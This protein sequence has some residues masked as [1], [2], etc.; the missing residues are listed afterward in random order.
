ME[1][2]NASDDLELLS[3]LETVHGTVHSHHQLYIRQNIHNITLGIRSTT[4][5]IGKLNSI[6]VLS[7]TNTSMNSALTFCRWCPVI[8]LVI[9]RVA[10]LHI[11]NNGKYTAQR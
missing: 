3:P 4:F 6:T 11:L 8:L 10:I 1:Y 5:R 9:L 2:C 7:W